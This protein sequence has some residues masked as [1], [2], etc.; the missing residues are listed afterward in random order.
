MIYSKKLKRSKEWRKAFE[1][2][3][4]ISGFEPMHQDEIDD[5]SLTMRQAWNLNVVW[6]GNVFADVQNTR[7]PID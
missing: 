3:E 6:L 4:S 7:T 2:Y 5:G 1:D